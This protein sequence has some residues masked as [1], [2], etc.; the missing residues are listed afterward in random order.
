MTRTRPAGRTSSRDRAA[1]ARPTQGVVSLAA[2]DLR[3]APDHRAELTSQLLMGE[4]VRLAGQDRSRHWWRIVNLAD[5]YRGW[6]RAWGVVPVSEA[7]AQRWRRRARRRVIVPFGA[8]HAGRRGSGALVSPLFLN[9]RVIAASGRGGDVAVELPDGRRG[10]TNA[11]ALGPLRGGAPGI[12]ER[13]RGLLGVPYLWGG[14]TPAGFDCSGFTQQVLWEQGIALPRDAHHQFLASRPL[15]E[16]EAPQPGD[17]VFFRGRDGRMGHV[18]IGLGGPWYAHCRG[19]VR[20]N[21]ADPRNRLS[22]SDLNATMA[23]WRRPP[24]S[25]AQAFI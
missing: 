24:R 25:T 23:G 3:A 19:I 2:L 16:N 6:V 12:A 5:G 1:R 7:R 10:Y 17:L 11:S 15:A 20:V 22:D 21:S 18:G 14:R 13:V 8:V 9:A 4:V